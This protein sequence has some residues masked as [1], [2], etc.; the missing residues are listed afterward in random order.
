MTLRSRHEAV[1][2]DLRARCPAAPLDVAL[3][4]ANPTPTPESAAPVDGGR[5]RVGDLLGLLRTEQSR[6]VERRLSSPRLFIVNQSNAPATLRQL[7]LL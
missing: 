5:R 7:S 2:D 3:D 4:E 1:S 6:D